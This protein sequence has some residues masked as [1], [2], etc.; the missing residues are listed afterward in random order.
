MAYTKTSD[1]IIIKAAL[2]EKGKKLLSRGKFKVAK[3]ALGDDEIDYRLYNNDPSPSA[4]YIPALKNANL[5]ESIK[6]GDSNIQF[7]LQ[8]FDDGVLYLSIQE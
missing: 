1:S 7:G 4:G 3:F 2:T 5:I 8:S 6:N